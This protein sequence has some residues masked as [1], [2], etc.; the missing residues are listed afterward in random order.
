[1]LEFHEKH[2]VG[3]HIAGKLIDSESFEK[4]KK[5]FHGVDGRN[6][7]DLEQ[8]LHPGPE[9]RPERLN[10]KGEKL[11]NPTPPPTPASP[12]LSL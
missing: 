9:L 1:M 12:V 6:V 7:T 5:K 11:S 8:L 2:T 3:K 4:M 10:N